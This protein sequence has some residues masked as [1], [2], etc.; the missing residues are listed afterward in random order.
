LIAL[1][2]LH[3]KEPKCILLLVHG[4]MVHDW[5]YERFEEM[6]GILYDRDFEI[7]HYCKRVSTY[8]LDSADWIL[9]DGCEGLPNSNF[10]AGHVPTLRHNKQRVLFL[11]SDE[12][13]AHLKIR[14][15]YSKQTIATL[16]KTDYPS[17]TRQAIYAFAI[18][19]QRLGMY[20]DIIILI[21]KW[22]ERTRRD[23]KWL[24]LEYP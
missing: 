20:R 6:T 12:T 21:C 7:A 11:Y 13:P 24:D 18:C 4:S 8:A 3:K 9:I 23:V 2:R 14:Y 16:Y 1:A 5:L 10:F 22:I 17:A 15:T 19:A